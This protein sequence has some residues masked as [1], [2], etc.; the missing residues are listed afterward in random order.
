MCFIFFKKIRERQLEKYWNNKYPIKNIIYRRVDKLGEKTIDVRL[1]L[2]HHN[3]YLPT[4]EGKTDDEIALNSLKWVIDNIK[5]IADSN[6]YKNNEYWAFGYETLYS[7]QGDCEDGAILLYEILRDNKIPS[8]KIRLTAGYVINPITN[9]KEGHAY[10]T[11]YCQEKNKWITLDWC[12][13]PDLT[14]IKDRIN[15]EENKIYSDVWFSFN[16][17]YAWTDNV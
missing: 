14:K 6:Q 5:Y 11:Y 4:I 9:K 12:Y 15:Y 7:R 13:F 3:Y 10:L 1:F 8:W 16:E 2:N 17:E